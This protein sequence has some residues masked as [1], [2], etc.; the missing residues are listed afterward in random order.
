[1]SV[2]AGQ[3]EHKAT[4]CNSVPG[5]FTEVV[6]RLD[7]RMRHGLRSC[8]LYCLLFLIVVN[9][10]SPKAASM[11]RESHGPPWNSAVASTRLVKIGD[12]TLQIDFGPG[13]FDLKQDDIVLWIETAGQAVAAYFGRFPVPRA[14]VLVLPVT[15]EKGVLT[16]TTWGEVGGFPAFTRMRVGQHTTLDDLKDDWTMTHEFVHIAFPSLPENHHWLEEGLATY[17]EPIARVQIGTLT[18]KQIWGDMHRDMRKGEP[19]AGDK[20]LDQTHTWASTYWGGA[21]FCMM[22]D[23]E[24]RQATGNQKGLQDAL[25]AVFA[26]GGTIDQD[27]P[28]EKTFAI[29]DKAT[30]TTVLSTL[31][32]SMGE[33]PQT[34][35]LNSLW[36]ELGVGVENG[37]LMLDDK[38]P[39]ANIREGITSPTLRPAVR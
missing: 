33:N 34:V 22:A 10:V 14:R 9:G 35:D 17:V 13:D 36:K 3:F 29:G 25:R 8:P 18:A 1:M 24:I 27:W 6:G 32:H 20:G 7:H 11:Q 5:S 4:K 23:I 28:I 19:G 21:L 38:A 39:L 15:G 12:S 16:G 31:Y 2:I 37:V 26:A 30:G